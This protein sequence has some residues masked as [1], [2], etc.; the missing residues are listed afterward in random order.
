MKLS[1]LFLGSIYLPLF[2]FS[3]FYE[4]IVP[5]HKVNIIEKKRSIQDKQL[6]INSVKNGNNPTFYPQTIRKYFGNTNFYPIG[7]LPNKKSFLCNEGYG[8]V[9]Y[10]TDIFGLR[11]NEDSWKRIIKNN[12][13]LLLG[14]SFIHGSCVEDENTIASVISKNKRFNVINL[15]MGGNGPHEY[16]G[17]LKTLVKPIINNSTK[18]TTVMLIFYAND[19]KNYPPKLHKYL[20]ELVRKAKPIISFNKDGD[21]LPNKIYLKILEDKISQNY[22]LN[23]KQIIDRINNRKITGYGVKTLIK[24][25]IT[26]RQ[27]RILMK[28]AGPNKFN[29]NENIPNK[30]QYSE[31]SPS[32]Q[33]IQYL[34]DICKSPCRP[35][36]GF[37]PNSNFWRPDRINR[38]YKVK[39][40]Y[41]EHLVEQANINKVPF[42][43]FKNIIDQNDKSNYAPKGPHLSILGNKKI[44]EF[45]SNQ[46]NI[47][48]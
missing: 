7:S 8:L 6:R 5:D 24:K 35:Y 31:N 9:T 30:M 18:T 27:L 17:T 28:L 40:E 32:A 48:D 34:S 42:L 20:S 19:D 21:G 4:L 39:N 22:P 45:I 25:I 11:N 2:L 33:A 15:G 36:V 46:I 12:N 26:L 44:G 3:L 10:K 13:I 41:L 29:F 37:I 38:M 1:L 14:D 47:E 43:N 23:K 16:T